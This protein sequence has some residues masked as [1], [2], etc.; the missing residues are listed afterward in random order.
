VKIVKLSG[1]GDLE[2]KMD[3][4]ETKLLKTCMEA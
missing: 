2:S 4:L 1:G 3:E